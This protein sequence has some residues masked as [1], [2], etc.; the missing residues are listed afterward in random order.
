VSLAAGVQP[1]SIWLFATG[2]PTGPAGDQKPAGIY[3]QILQVAG[4][5]WQQWAEYPGGIKT[6][7][8][9]NVPTPGNLYLF[10]TATGPGDQP[11][12]I[13]N[14]KPCVNDLSGT[15]WN[16]LG[17]VAFDTDVAVAS[18]FALSA[19]IAIS[20]AGPT[21]FGQLYLPGHIYYRIVPD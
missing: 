15:G 20:V 9:P 13:L 6:E 16:D 1:G 3:R 19:K 4:Q 12:G 10:A 17:D 2:L 18:A 11:A 21:H 8:A 7:L 14:R 5:S